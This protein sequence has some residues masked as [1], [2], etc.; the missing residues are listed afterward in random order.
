MLLKTLKPI[1]SSSRNTALVRFSKKKNNPL[2]KETKGISKNPSGRNHTGKITSFHR[3]GGHK[4]SFRKI[5]FGYLNDLNIVENIEYDPNRSARILR[6]FSIDRKNHI[7]VLGTDNIKIGN[8]VRPN[9]KSALRLG[10]RKNL[11][12]IPLGSMVHSLGT[13]FRPNLGVLQRSAGV[14]AQIIKKSTDS[15]MI[16]LNSGNIICLF[17]H[18]SAVIGSVSNI[19]HRHKNLG[20]AGRKRWLNFRPRVRGVAMNPI[21]HPHGGGEGKSSGGRPSVT[22]W[23]RPAHG[24]KTKKKFIS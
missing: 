3:G 22:P 15:C 2:K 1:N 23:A 14:F 16:K 21:D 6:L 20:K 13:Q 5:N 11:R 24:K 10:N 8:L 4:R 17:P 19:E 9:N 7:Y 12:D 18:I